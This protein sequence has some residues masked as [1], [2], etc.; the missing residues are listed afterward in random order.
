MKLGRIPQ[1][2]LFLLS[3]GCTFNLFYIDQ[4]KK[5]VWKKGDSTLVLRRSML[6]TATDG[7]FFIRSYGEVFGGV[8]SSLLVPCSQEVLKCLT[9]NL[10]P[11]FKDRYTGLGAQ[12]LALKNAFQVLF[13]QLYFNKKICRS[14]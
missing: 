2:G 9:Q 12:T 10:S 6:W 11:N 13:F 1:Q 7:G 3:K 8:T 14:S 5:T 4:V